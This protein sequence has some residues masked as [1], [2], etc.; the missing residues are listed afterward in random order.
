MSFFPQVELGEAFGPFALFREKLGF[1]PNLFRAQTL[2]PRVIEAEAQVAG[3]VLLK[4]GS[5]SRTQKECLLLA[6]AGAKQ[7]A[8][9][10][11]AHWEMLRSLGL[12]VRQ[13]DQIL[14]DHHRAGLSTADVALMDFGLAL[15]QRPTWVGRKDI[16]GLRRHGFTDGQILEA[17]VVSALTDFLCALSE[18]LGAKPD[19]EPKKVASPRALLPRSATHRGRDPDG[20]H[21]HEQATSCLRSAPLSPDTFGPFVFFRERFGFIPNIFHAQTLRPNVLEAEAQM[22]RTV[23]LTE[24]L[25]AL[26]DKRNCSMREGERMEWIGLSIGG[27]VFTITRAGAAGRMGGGRQPVG[28]R[29]PLVA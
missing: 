11:T 8:Y 24:D 16:A 7:N 17:V 1:V 6:I 2:L 27:L 15:S 18:G 9:C 12:T 5:L 10:V 25:L 23:L 29:P 22:V 14:T 28:Q 26:P 13:L 3:T 19:F 20:V 4:E 21:A